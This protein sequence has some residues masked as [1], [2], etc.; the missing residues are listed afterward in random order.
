VK[1]K[2]MSLS[3]ILI[4]VQIDDAFT[5]RVSAALLTRCARAVLRH[6]KVD[7][8]VEL[9]VAV[10]DDRTMRRL[11]RT[12]RDVDAATDVL[13]FGDAGEPGFVQPPG[14]HRYLGDVAISFPMA[15][16]Q[17]ARAGHALD[18]ELQL[19]T[20]HGVLHLLGHDHADDAERSRMWTAQ[21]EILAALGVPAVVAS[22]ESA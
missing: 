4:E 7:G 20:V 10:S 3:E 22:L 1:K 11:N 21:S 2:R 5:E 17:A 12:Y 14:A 19:L 18:A 15:E 6:Q 9:T 8:P 16:A 13:A